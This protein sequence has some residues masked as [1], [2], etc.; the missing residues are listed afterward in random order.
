[1][2]VKRVL[3]ARKVFHLNVVGNG[4]FKPNF[5]QHDFGILVKRSPLELLSQT[6]LEPYV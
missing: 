3:W 1:M 4:Y 6:S 2:T 5:W